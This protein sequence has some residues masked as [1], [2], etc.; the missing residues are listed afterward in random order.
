[1]KLEKKLITL[2]SIG[3]LSLTMIHFINKFIS[4]SSTIDSLLS[5]SDERIYNWR[6]GDI[7]YTKKG[8][9]KP[10]LLIHNLTPCS[11]GYE[12]NQFQKELLKEYTVYTI[13]LL[14]CGR[15]DKPNL[16]YTNFLYV[17]LICDFI[18]NVIKDKTDIIV[19]GNAGSIALMSA[20]N[21]DSIINQII[22]I[23]PQNLKELYKIPTKR[24]KTAKFILDTPIIGTM[25]Y[26]IIHSKKNIDS[27]LI[28]EGFYNPANLSE[29]IVKAYY[30]AAHNN[31]GYSKYLFSSVKSQYMNANIF[32]C[33][34]KLNNS[35]YILTSDGN[36]ENLIN[37]KEYKDIM[38][39]IEIIELSN[40]KQL[41][42]L[43]SPEKVLEQ[44]KILFTE[45]M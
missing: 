17:Q 12:W 16:T 20:L 15:S 43:E 25:I 21:D 1:M 32:H 24:T 5:E 38:P 30:E 22:L 42:H 2:A 29:N 41:P 37:A 7:F 14:G 35:I 9:G 44:T 3:G 10:L 28:T 11:S 6:F 23:N 40:V 8:E 36:P 34:K 33:L 19:S 45:K 27:Q 18:K 4:Y 31:H 26:N 13:D 39:S